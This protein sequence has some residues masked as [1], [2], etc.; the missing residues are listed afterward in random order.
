MR[1]SRFKPISNDEFHRLH[2]T[3]S[4]LLHFE[5]GK[6]YNDWEI[7]VHGIRIEFQNERGMRRTATYLPEVA[8]EQGIKHNSIIFHFPGVL[9]IIIYQLYQIFSMI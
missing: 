3:V 9:I 1:D 2:V 6:D 8:E 5:E 4:I 7:G